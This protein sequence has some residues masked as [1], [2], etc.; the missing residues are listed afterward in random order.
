MTE[1]KDNSFLTFAQKEGVAEIPDG[2]FRLK[3]LSPRTRSH[4]WM[5]TND[6]IGD[7]TSEYNFIRQPLTNLIGVW[8]VDRLHKPVDELPNHRTKLSEL[9][10]SLVLKGTYV[11]VLEFIECLLRHDRGG[12]VL[13]RFAARVRAALEQTNCGYRLLMQPLPQIIQASTTEEAAT[14]TQAISDTASD[15]LKGAQQHLVKAA[16]TLRDG[17]YAGSV[18]ESIHAVE[19]VCKVISGDQKADLRKAL[20]QL[21]KKS[22]IHPAF[23]EGLNKLY[24]FTS[25]EKGV[26]HASLGD[27]D[28][29]HED[30][31]FMIGACA[32]FVSFLLHKN[33]RGST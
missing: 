23:K 11:D 14:L 6:L 20:E 13:G 2:T 12:A 9:L 21:D 33:R 8:W 27:S 32:A 17:D 7:N 26:R 16:E 31:Q 5:I 29:T 25:D 22:R 10:K 24:A 28:V 30:A 4:L 19:S 18:R 3:E 15:P 1:N